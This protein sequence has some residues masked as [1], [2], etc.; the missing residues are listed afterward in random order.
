MGGLHAQLKHPYTRGQRV[1]DNFM[2]GSVPRYRGIKNEV[3]AT[4]K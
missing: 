2:Q 3:Q 1:G 4:R